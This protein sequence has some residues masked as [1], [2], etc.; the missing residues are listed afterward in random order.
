QLSDDTFTVYDSVDQY[1]SRKG[2]PS[3]IDKDQ[4]DTSQ[5]DKQYLNM[6]TLLISKEI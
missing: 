2:L 1:N 3:F 5:M 6:R 4:V